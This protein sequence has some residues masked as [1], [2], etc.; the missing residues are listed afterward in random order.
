MSKQKKEKRYKNMANF[1]FKNATEDVLL[2]SHLM[3]GREQRTTTEMARKYEKGFTIIDFD[4]V[5]QEKEDGTKS[6]YVCILFKEDENSYYCGGLI[7]TKIVKEWLSNFNSIEE[8]VKELQ[9]QGGVKIALEETK[10]KD[11]KN[12]LTTV[13]V[14]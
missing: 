7:L 9:A 11:G 14:M 10:T 13:K 12:N 1:N 2:L 4:L 6:E 3:K 5:E 8:C